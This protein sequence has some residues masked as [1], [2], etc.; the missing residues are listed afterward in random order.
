MVYNA[1]IPTVSNLV[2]NHPNAIRY[3]R[4]RL[5]LRTKDLAAVIGHTPSKTGSWQR[6]WVLPRPQTA[7]AISA[8]VQCPVEI[9]YLEQF[10]AIR[11]VVRRR[12]AAI[13]ETP[14]PW[15]PLLA[16][17]ARGH[18]SR[19]SLRGSCPLF[20]PEF[21]NCGNDPVS[22]RCAMHMKHSDCHPL[23]SYRHVHHLE[24]TTLAHQ[25]GCSPK[26]LYRW[27]R[28]LTQPRMAWAVR[29]SQV[30]QLPLEQLFGGGST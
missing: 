1:C 26:S 22:L 4:R 23:T 9:L 24:R 21:G 18:T 28:G 11:K 10:Q 7:L 13:L 12:T 6:G 2:M 27:E 20:L 19:C 3:Y 15:V 30:T 16:V 17:L 5:S 14:Q 29:A 25:I 8:A